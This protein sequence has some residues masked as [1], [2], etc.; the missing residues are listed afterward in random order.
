M[1]ITMTANIR[2][3]KR[4]LFVF[5]TIIVLGLGVWA[6]DEFVKYRIFP[7][8]WGVVETG[9][10]YRSGQLHPSLIKKTLIK[11]NIQVIVDL[12]GRDP[13][14]PHQQTEEEVI[15]SLGIE[16]ERFPLAGNGTGDIEHYTEALAAIV[17]ARDAH[18]P[19]LVHCAAGSQRTGGV[20]ACYRMLIEKRSPA[21]AY[22]E[23]IQ[24]DW[25]EQSDSVLLTFI[26]DHMPELVAQLVELGVLEEIPNPLPVLSR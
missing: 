13:S 12:T 21:F 25:D 8:R 17:R 22:H 19:V 20:I 24:Y 7:K 5:G 1:A 15:K 4:F 9:R 3:S 6:W 16:H 23:M 14:D 2:S 18:K 10:I 11:H 26:N